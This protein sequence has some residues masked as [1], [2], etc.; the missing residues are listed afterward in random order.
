MLPSDLQYTLPS[1]DELIDSDDFPVNNEDQNF[2]PNVLLFL[3]DGLM[4]KAIAI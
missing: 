3:L 4:L 2:V 1:S